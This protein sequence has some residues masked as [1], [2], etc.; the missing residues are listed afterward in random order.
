MADLVKKKKKRRLFVDCHEIKVFKS[1]H[2]KQAA[3]CSQRGA[4]DF[5]LISV[6]MQMLALLQICR[7][8]QTHYSSHIPA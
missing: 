8:V 1:R 3:F 4:I 5:N 2:A 6:E 7:D